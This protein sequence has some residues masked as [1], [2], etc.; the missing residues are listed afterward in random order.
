MIKITIED[1]GTCSSAT[2]CIPSKVSYGGTKQSQKEIYYFG[3]PP[4]KPE[5]LSD[6]L[7]RTKG[8]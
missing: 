7:K 8:K 5:S 3:K 1:F 6:Y 2:S 4:K